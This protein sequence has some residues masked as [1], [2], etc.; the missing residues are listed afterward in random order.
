MIRWPG[1]IRPKTISDAMVQ[2]ID[3]APTLLNVTGS[4][5]PTWLQGVSLVPII[6]GKKTSLD[7]PYLYYHYYEFSTDH[8]VVPHLGLRGKS[9]YLG[10][11]VSSSKRINSKTSDL[12]C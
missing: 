8:T 1:H 11:I 5:V 4:D 7:R 3:F 2:N 10:S 12:L 6:T 9:Y